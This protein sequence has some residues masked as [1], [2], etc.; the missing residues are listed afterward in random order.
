MLS[1][2]LSILQGSCSQLNFWRGS[3]IILCVFASLRLPGIGVPLASDEL[4]TVSLWAQMPYLK[5]F[6]N[7]QYPN[8]HIFLSLLLSFILKTFGLKEWLLRAPVLICGLVSLY[9]SYQLAKR[10]SGNICV[11]F[12]TAFLM[13]IS[14]KHVYY[15]TNARGYM[16]VMMLALMAVT[17]ALERIEGR[18]FSTVLKG[19]NGSLALLGWVAI[20]IVGTWTI[21]TFIFFEFSVAIFFTVVMLINSR[22]AFVKN[23]SLAI[24][25]FSCVVGG[26]GFYWQYYVLIDPAMLAAATSTVATTTF[27]QFFPGLLTDW[28]NPFAMVGIPFLLLALVGMRWMF[29]KKRVAGFLL[30]CVLLGPISIGIFGFMFGKLPTVPY[31]RTYFYLQPFFIMLGV[32]GAREAGSWCL[33]LIMPKGRSYEKQIQAI[34]WMLAGGLFLVSGFKFFQ[35]TYLQRMSREPFHK[36]HDFVKKLNEHDLLLA[37]HNIHVEF[38]LYGAGDM[39]RRVD[40]IL[41]SGKLGDVYFLEYKKEGLLEK[42]ATKVLEERFIDFPALTGNADK[43]GIRLPGNAMERVEQFGPFVFYRL[44]KNWLHPLKNWKHVKLDADLLKTNAVRWEKGSRPL[45][46]FQDSFTVAIENT[47]SLFRNASGLTL[48]L[49]A[50]T[51][52]QNNFSAVLLGGQMKAGAISLDPGWLA[53]A[54]IL[55]HP[56]GSTIFNHPWNPAIFISQGAG[57]LSVLDVKFAEPMRSGAA[58]NFLSY[59][60]EEPEGK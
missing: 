37:S 2:I 15:S 46:R 19:L 20:W 51:G 28:L 22:I 54:W 56:Y 16:V 21:P 18:R 49:I 3:F 45:I 50:L 7:Y 35:H 29:L 4:A 41:D 12:F 25:L 32:M 9:L 39:R 53:N 23:M 44:K 24:P 38:Y 11:G 34:V 6:S 33:T 8:N 57:R 10:V 43:R 13:A 48:N 17:H 42:Q 31:S 40:N 30:A 52:D 58:K 27:T 60:I 55:D 59:R 47:E 14:E 5:I 26:I 1:P 36:V